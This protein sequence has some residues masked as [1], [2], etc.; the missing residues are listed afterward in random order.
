MQSRAMATAFALGVLAVGVTAAPATAST[1]PRVIH[2]GVI[3]RQDV[4]STSAS[5]ADTVAEPDVAVSPLDAKIA[6]AAVQ[7][8]RLPLSGSLAVSVTW[9][10]DGGRTWTHAPLPKLTKS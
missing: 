8:G 3:D 10:H 5:E 1:G 9:T 6:V 7:G 2:L 4:P